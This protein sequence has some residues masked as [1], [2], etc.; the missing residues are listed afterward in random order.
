MFYLGR[1]SR[2]LKNAA[3]P[4]MASMAKGNDAFLLFLRSINA[5]A[6]R[7]DP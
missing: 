1:P 5:A 4:I 7:S 2:L 3:M 6:A